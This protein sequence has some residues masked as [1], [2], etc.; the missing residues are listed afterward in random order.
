MSSTCEEVL[1][2][3]GPLQGLGIARQSNPGRRIENAER[4]P[5]PQGSVT[6]THQRLQSPKDFPEVAATEHLRA[7]LPRTSF[8][9]HTNYQP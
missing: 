7:Q 1:E 9:G 6:A 5:L 4:V 3:L 2:E 8:R